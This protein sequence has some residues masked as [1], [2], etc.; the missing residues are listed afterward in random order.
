MNKIEISLLKLEIESI[1]TQRDQLDDDQSCLELSEYESYLR[2]R[3]L[4]N[5]KI[6][7]RENLLNQQKKKNAPTY[8]YASM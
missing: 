4:L 3:S 1:R 8:N 5:Y 2:K 6:E 7:Y